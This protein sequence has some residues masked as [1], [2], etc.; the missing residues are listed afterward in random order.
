MPDSHMPFYGDDFFSAVEMMGEVLGFKYLRC[1]WFYWSH[2][3]C[4]GIPDD[5]EQMRNLCRCELGTWARTKGTIFDNDKFFVLESGKWHQ[6]RARKEWNLSLERLTDRYNQTSAATAARL[7]KRNVT[8]NVGN[9]VGVEKKGRELSNPQKHGKTVQDL[10]TNNVTS[11]VTSNV[12]LTKPEPEPE[13][14][15]AGSERAFPEV[16]SRMSLSEVKATA[17]MIGLAEW[18]AVDWF[19]EMEGCGWRDHNQRPIHNARSVMVRV[20]T[21]WESDGRPMSPP[22]PKT[23]PHEIRKGKSVAI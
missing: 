11:N 7:V 14:S 5:D 1:V 23:Q 20:K 22:K 21:K 4:E 10:D 2:L 15:T 12:T 17:V 8:L 13:P 9:D 18:K 19:H 3:H 16:V 6:K